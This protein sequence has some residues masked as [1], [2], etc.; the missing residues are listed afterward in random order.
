LKSASKKWKDFKVVLKRKY[1]NP[2]LSRRQNISN[3]CAKGIPA[4]QWVWLVNHWKSDEGQLKSEKNKATRALQLNS[5]HTTG[6]RSNAVVLDQLELKVDKL[7]VLSSMLQHI[8]EKMESQ[9]MITAVT[10]LMKLDEDLMRI[11]L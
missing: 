11:L 5:R 1:F 10:K 6:S 7:G 9:L 4:P 2:N 3:G 8:P